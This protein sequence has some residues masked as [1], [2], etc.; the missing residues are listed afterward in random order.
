MKVVYESI[1]ADLQKVIENAALNNRR[2]QYIELTKDEYRALGAEVGTYLKYDTD[3]TEWF[4]M[5]VKL[6]VV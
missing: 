6:V 3:N 4:F 2:I 5:G 1:A